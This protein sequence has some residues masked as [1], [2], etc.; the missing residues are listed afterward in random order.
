MVL[1]R[2]NGTKGVGSE[3]MTRNRGLPQF[4]VLQ[5]AEDDIGAYAKL[6]AIYYDGEIVIRWGLDPFTYGNLKRAVSNRYF[7]TMPGI[8]YEY[9]L[10]TSYS[11][12][13]KKDYVGYL[14]CIL[15]K[16]TKQIEFN[17]S[18]LFAG[19]IEWMRKVKGI[20]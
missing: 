9:K 5:I 14:E 6:K 3:N 7:E 10:I 16:Q 13:R 1:A 8:V 2:T 20:T 18:E 11:H 15:G 19:N 4:E 17:C 12:N